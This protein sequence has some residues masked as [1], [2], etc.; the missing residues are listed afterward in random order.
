MMYLS[1]GAVS[2][3]GGSGLEFDKMLESA[4]PSVK[5]ELASE[6]KKTMKECETLSFAPDAVVG[7]LKNDV[8]SKVKKV[9]ALVKKMIDVGIGDNAV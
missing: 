2:D 5:R 3:Q 4:P 8:S 1:L 9:N 6:I 7:D